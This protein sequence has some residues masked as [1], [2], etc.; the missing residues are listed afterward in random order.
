[1]A[2]HT[3]GSVQRRNNGE[4]SD[5]HDNGDTSDSVVKDNNSTHSPGQSFSTQPVKRFVNQTLVPITLL[6]LMPNFVMVIW[7]TIVHCHGSYLKMVSVLFEKSVFSGLVHIWSLTRSP[8]PV[9]IGSL[10]LYCAYAL[11]MMKLLP[12]K[13]VYGPM[14]P[15]GNIPEYKDNGF[16]FFVMTIGMFWAF[17]LLLRPFGISPSIYYDKMDEICVTLNTFSLVFCAFLY[18]KGKLAPSTTDSGSSGN[19]IFDYYW[20]MELYPRIFGFDVKVFTNC[21]FGLIIWALMVCIHAVKSYELHGFVDSMFV[22]ALLQIVYLAKFYWWEAGYLSTIDIMVDRAGFYICWGCLALVPVLYTSVTC[23]LVTHPVRLGLAVSAAMIF[24][25]L[26]SIYT[27]YEA[28]AQKQKV[29]KT[30]GDCL[31]WGKT[32]DIIRAKYQ[33][34][35]G[36]IKDSILLASGWW[37]MSRHFHYIPEIMLA[38]MWTLPALF[39]NLM[40]YSYV[41]ILTIILTHRSSRDEEK[42]SS[43]YGHFWRQYCNKVPYRIIPNLF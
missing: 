21:R 41:I 12:G 31:I 24:I 13:T 25:G 16:L 7:Y 23:Y 1:M 11:A 4:D 32:P 28:D 6:L 5:I 40:P 20:G 36:G 22:S 9:I 29:R 34:E 3:N 2:D 17:V 30:N 42:C 15:K 27:N 35:N 18:L 38:L 10:V 37:G 14:T 26:L 8:S 33:L 43:K 19:I 39:E